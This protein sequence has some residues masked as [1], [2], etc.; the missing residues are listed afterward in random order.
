MG[1]VDSLLPPPNDGRFQVRFFNQVGETAMVTLYDSK[2]ALVYRK[3]YPTTAPYTSLQVT[4][5]NIPA[6]SYLVMVN[7]EDGRK[8]GAKWVTI[9]R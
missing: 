7:G 3:Q 2:G 4:L 8:I 6:G 5:P 1:R 9:Y